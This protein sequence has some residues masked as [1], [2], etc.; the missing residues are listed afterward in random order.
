MSE[1]DVLNEILNNK[2]F[3]DAHHF[4]IDESYEC[5][6][7]SEKRL[8]KYLEERGYKN[9]DINYTL[10]RLIECGEDIL[11]NDGYFIK[12]NIGYILFEKRIEDENLDKEELKRENKPLYFTRDLRLL[13]KL[14]RLL[15]EYSL[16]FGDDVGIILWGDNIGYHQVGLVGY[17]I[18]R[19]EEIKEIYETYK[20]C[21][22]PRKLFNIKGERIDETPPSDVEWTETMKKYNSNEWG[23]KLLN[24][25][26]IRKDWVEKRIEIATDPKKRMK[27]DRKMK[28]F[29]EE[30]KKREE[31]Y[32]K[33]YHKK[34]KEGYFDN[35]VEIFKN[36]N[37]LN[38]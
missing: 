29:K 16:K 27:E 35:L 30:T 13:R 36:E 22:K 2:C 21:N 19:E 24:I 8:R 14:K 3:R 28:K 9:N 33:E 4:I 23:S 17:G 20:K 18:Y 12:P 32:M 25:L 26:I 1:V 15:N 10:K 5:K 34:M 38:H 6:T 7:V 31:E 37:V 11:A